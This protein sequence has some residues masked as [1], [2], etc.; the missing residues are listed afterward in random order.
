MLS[1]SATI[2]YNISNTLAAHCANI[3]A[4]GALYVIYIYTHI[5]RHIS[6]LV[7]YESVSHPYRAG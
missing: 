3:A 6:R 2:S 1:V 5:D 7:S 4:A